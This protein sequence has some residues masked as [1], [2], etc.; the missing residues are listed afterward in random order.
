VITEL[1][2]ENFLFVRKAHLDF[3]QGLNVITGETGAGKSLLLEGVKLILGKKGK[4]GLVINGSSGAKVHAVFN[5][6]EAP[7]PREFLEA[8]GFLND[9][10][11]DSLVIT[12]TFRR[13]GSEKIFI[14]GIMATSTAL[15]DLGRHLMEIHGQNEHQTL[16]LPEFQ[17]KLLDRTGALPHSRRLEELRKSSLDYRTLR[18]E[19]EGLEERLQAGSRRLA[20][21]Q[22]SLNQME[23]LDLKSP[24]EEETLRQEADR[25]MHSE[26]IANSLFDAIEALAGSESGGSGAVTLLRRC[27]DALHQAMAFDPDLTA[28]HGRLD[29]LFYDAEDAEKDLQTSNDGVIHDPARL[30]ALNSRLAE[31]GRACRRFGTDAAGLISL[32]KKASLEI[33][34]LTA[35]DSTREKLRTAI[36]RAQERF[37]E[38]H[39]AVS[40]ARRKLAVTLQKLVSQTMEKLGFAS[41]HFQVDLRPIEPGP[42][43]SEAVEFMVSLNPG[44]SPGPL[45]KIASGGELSRVALALKRVLASGD[46]LPT[47]LFDEIDAGIGGTTAEAVAKS[48]KELGG[49][50]QVILV[51]HLHQ[52]AKEGTRHFTV[53]K[54]VEG[55]QTFVSIESVTGEQREVEIARMV[56]RT[57]ADGIAFARS[58]LAK[59][60][61]QNEETRVRE[62]PPARRAK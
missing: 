10:N 23:T 49:E 17:R 50:K 56:G 29:T 62:R 54:T 34:E 6:S 5:L 25:L 60:N 40:T 11:P 44:A 36:D 22:D 53:T 35:P 30:V 19:L 20:E 21:L 38:A 32:R 47:L 52:I 1:V 31:I 12:R 48:L 58:I 15:K 14:N 2:L 13:E 26:S 9:E 33:A 37:Q 45:R 16:L 3:G 61:S 55:S 28:L 39:Q 24:D 4:A 59:G 43:G 18:A 7:A 8:Q 27:R 51:T 42:E 57:D 46:E 41:A